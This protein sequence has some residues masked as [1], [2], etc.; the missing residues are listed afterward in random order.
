MLE[1]EITYGRICPAAGLVVFWLIV[2]G[3]PVRAVTI[4]LISKL[5][6]QR[7]PRVL[8]CTAAVKLFVRSNSLND[9]SR[10]RNSEEIA[11]SSSPPAA[12]S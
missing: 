1:F 9:R 10:L 5:R 8:Y 2:V 12:K 11:R 3:S 4:G 7:L 6:T